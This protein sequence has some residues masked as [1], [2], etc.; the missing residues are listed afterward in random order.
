MKR[1]KSY[2]RLKSFHVSRPFYPVGAG[3]RMKV[4][5]TQSVVK[6]PDDGERGWGRRE[7]ER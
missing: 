1:T 7:G 6:V 4:I 2:A 5:H 3:E